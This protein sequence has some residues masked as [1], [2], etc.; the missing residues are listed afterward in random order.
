MG[1]K[2]ENAVATDGAVWVSLNA[3]DGRGVAR[4]DTET[5]EVTT[6]RTGHPVY[7]VWGDDEALWAG[8]GPRDCS[9]PGAAV[10]IDPETGAITGWVEAACPFWAAEIDGRLAIA[11]DQTM[12]IDWFDVGE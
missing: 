1:E 4:I 3:E 6:V 5:L 10:R 11:N 7:A 9:T 12:E 2:P 8:T